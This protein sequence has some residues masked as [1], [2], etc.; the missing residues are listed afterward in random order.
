M[1]NIEVNQKLN[2]L[3]QL[4]DVLDGDQY[5]MAAATIYTNYY[6][7]KVNSSNE[8]IERQTLMD[9]VNLMLYKHNINEVSYFFFRKFI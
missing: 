8:K 1:T 6:L 3:K 5:R 4:R 7:N 2:H 9:R